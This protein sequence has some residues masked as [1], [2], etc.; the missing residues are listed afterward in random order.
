MFVDCGS[1]GQ[2]EL[3]ADG[4]VLL[5]ANGAWDNNADSTPPNS[6]R[7]RLRVDDGTTLVEAGFGQATT[8]H[9]FTAMGGEPVRSGAVGLTAV[10]NPLPA[11]SHKFD[12][13]CNETEAEVALSPTTISAV[14]LGGS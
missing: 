7:C 14:L 4:R 12:L 2:I 9:T 8:T 1:T 13:E 6:G 11:G 5:V 10:T 3:P